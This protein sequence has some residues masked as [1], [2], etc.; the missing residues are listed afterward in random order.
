MR[1]A[2]M[3]Y[4]FKA[5]RQQGFDLQGDCRSSSLILVD[6]E[7]EGPSDPITMFYYIKVECQQGFDLFQTGKSLWLILVDSS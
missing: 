7:C 5:E 3:L 4:N 6:S 2:H 1:I